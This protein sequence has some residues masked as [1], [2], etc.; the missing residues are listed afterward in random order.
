MPS[1]FVSVFCKRISCPS[2]QTLLAFRRSR[3]AYPEKA[4]VEGHLASCDFC[5]AELQLLT[6]HH[7]ETEEY[8]FAEMPTQ[9]RRLAQSLLRRGS[10]PFKFSELRENL[11]AR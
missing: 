5:S 3:L 6:L 9:L 11:R 4:Y 1:S 8:A 10:V 7:N 2:S